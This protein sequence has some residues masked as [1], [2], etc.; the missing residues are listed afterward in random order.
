MR[1]LETYQELLDIDHIGVADLEPYQ[2]EIRTE[3][4]DAVC[5]FPRSVTLG[6]T[7]PYA[8]V[9]QLGERDDGPSRLNYSRHAY[10]VI[11]YRLDGAAS[12]LASALQRSGAR[13]LPIPASQSVDSDRLYP[14]LSHKLGAHLAG[15]GWIGKSC[16]LITPQYGPRVRWIT[17]LT[18]APFNPTGEPQAEKC[19]GCMK[20]VDICPAQA[21][22]GRAYQMGEPRQLRFDV[23]KCSAHLSQMEEIYGVRTCGKCL[24]VCPYG[25]R[26]KPVT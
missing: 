21:Y 23:H 17:V 20:C 7:L 4:G 13:S 6:I 16:L 9:D 12:R 26:K 15:L 2:D 18:D 3:F 5:G 11:N 22:T 8:V 10:D 25:N 19:G 14:A 24:I 1:E